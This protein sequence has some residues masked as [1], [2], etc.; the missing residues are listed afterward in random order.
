[1]IDEVGNKEVFRREVNKAWERQI[2][3]R[4]ERRRLRKN[5]ETEDPPSQYWGK[6]GDDFI[7]NAQGETM[8]NWFRQIRR[9]MPAEAEAPPG[10]DP[11]KRAMHP[12]EA[13]KVLHLSAATKEDI[14][15]RFELLM[16]ANGDKGA[17]QYLHD[18]IAH[19]R[20]VAMDQLNKGTLKRHFKVK[21][22][23]NPP[24]P[25]PPTTA[26]PP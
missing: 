2:L 8:R 23:D 4:M 17:S 15:K 24:P 18:K 3:S 19:A 9:E 16:A 22:D 7:G 14:E 12:S 1:L 10:T 6:E 20:D 25:P 11:N 21:K 5:L 26:P 13:V